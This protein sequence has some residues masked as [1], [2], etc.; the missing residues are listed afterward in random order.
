M[1][2]GLIAPFDDSSLS[3]DVYASILARIRKHIEVGEAGWDDE[4]KEKMR[5]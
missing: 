4:R 5:S 2:A 3:D 1:D